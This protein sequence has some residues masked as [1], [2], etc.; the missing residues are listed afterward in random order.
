M[1]N[2]DSS[3]NSID[4]GD[5]TSLLKI[6]EG[7]QLD[8]ETER[9]VLRN[10]EENMPSEL[11]IRMRIMYTIYSFFCYCSTSSAPGNNLFNINVNRGFN[12]FNIAGF[13]IA[14]FILFLNNLLGEG[15]AADL[16]GL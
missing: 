3:G 15:W 1:D 16:L 2:G 7:S 8:E 13:G 10:L 4:D 9:E 14:F 11:E 12:K 6:R 5:D